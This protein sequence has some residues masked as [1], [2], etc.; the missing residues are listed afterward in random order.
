MKNLLT[1]LLV[2]VA[3]TTAGFISVKKNVVKPKPPTA[4]AQ[5][6]RLANAFKAMLSAEQIA[7]LEIPLSKAAATKWTNIPGGASN[8]NGLQFSTL[9]P[10]QLTAAKAIIKAA[11]G[12]T[13]NEG[14]DEFL[15]IGQA[16]SVIGASG[17]KG[18]GPGEYI[19]AFLGKPSET[20]TWM[21]QFGGHH[22]AQNVVYSKGSTA[23]ATPIFLGGDPREWTTGTLKYQPMAQERTAM[24]AL[25][26]SL[27]EAQLAKAKLTEKFP[28]VVLG[29]TKDGRF[30]A[31]KSGIRVSELS[32][33][34]RAGVIKAMM[35]WLDDIDADLKARLLKTYTKELA[36]TYVCYAG[37]P[38]GKSGNADSFLQEV[39]DYVRIDGPGVWIEFSCQPG[40]FSKLAHYHTVFR[41]HRLDY[42]NLWNF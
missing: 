31:E 1:C 19:I 20:E 24:A 10:E 27:T 34:A 41:D 29:T 15:K 37:N 4:A 22:Y 21:L 28:D 6:F 11:S 33:A 2:A 13:V 5:V 32:T 9:T 12:S 25:L 40:V 18:Y 38:E 17:K 30:P 3:L 39:S 23:S 8:R 7:R 36:D 42:N 16:D 14:Y 35:P 26:A